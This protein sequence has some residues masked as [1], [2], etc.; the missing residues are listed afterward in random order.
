MVGGDISGVN[1]VSTAT[2]NVINLTYGE[3]AAHLN[4]QVGGD[5]ELRS[6]DSPRSSSSM[7]GS[8]NDFGREMANFGR[9]MGKLGQE[10]SREISEAVKSAGWAKGTNIADDIARPRRK[11]TSGAAACGGRGASGAAPC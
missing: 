2:G 7:G 3:G 10:L 9:E 6:S 4:L 1:I 5:L 11:G 8:W